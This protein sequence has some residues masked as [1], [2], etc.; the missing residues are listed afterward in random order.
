MKKLPITTQNK[1]VVVSWVY[2]WARQQEMSIHEQR[3]ILRILEFCQDELKGVKIKDHLCKLEH[4]KYDV[5]IEMPASLAIFKNLEADTITETLETLAKRYFKYEDD[6]RW[7]M[8]SFISSPEYIKGSGIMKFRVDNKIWDVWLNFS[9]GYRRFELNKALALPTTYS[10]QFYML[11]SGSEKPISFTIEQFKEWLGIAPEA[12]KRKDGKDRIDHLEERVI[13]PA[14]RALDES[15]PYTF[16]YSKIKQNPLNKRSRVTGFTF[17]AKYQ[18]QFRD[19]ALESKVL[20]A[21]VSA[22]FA[23]RPEIYNYLRQQCGFS[24]SDLNNTKEIWL[25]AQDVFEDPLLEIA[26]LKAKAREA[27]KTPQAFIVAY[28]KGKISDAMSKKK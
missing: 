17:T 6:K 15:C 24:A 2:T 25:Q 23:I 28:I 27:K 20:Q 4:N 18:P 26:M 8:C 10:V 9:K 7:W 3:I 11:M 5:T 14:Q 1:D 13:K 22:S 12:Y 21:K 16:T 19:E